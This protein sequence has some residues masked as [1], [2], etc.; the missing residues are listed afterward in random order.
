MK[1][2]EVHVGVDIAKDSLEVS[3]FDSKEPVVE[4]TFAGLES[5]VRRIKELGRP[6][7]V[8]CEATGGFEHGLVCACLDAGI[9]VA[10][11]NARRVRR[12]AQSQ[13]V[14]AKTDRIDARVIRDYAERSELRLRE[15]RA[16]WQVQAK[17]LL[18][19]R[20]ELSSMLVQEKNRL[21]ISP[22]DRVRRSIGEIVAAI[23]AQ[24]KQIDA[25]LKI[26]VKKNAEFAKSVARICG[27]KGVGVLSAMALLAFVPELG[28]VS[29]NEAAALVGVAPYNDDSG[30]V[31]GKRR[32]TGGR[33][34]VRKTL[35]MAALSASVHNPLLSAFHQRLVQK[36]KPHKVALTAVIR[37]IV[38]LANRLLADPEFELA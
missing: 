7:M 27:I 2:Y 17:A 5:L 25:E 24:I 10:V 9:P 3:P 23:R 1:A 32:T 18:T 6:A 11:V 14:L 19:R 22:D 28:E 29:G 35:Y 15:R 34:E 12:Y 21:G 16:A 13:G 30:T 36:G 37:K 31:K 8:C 26:L 4:N 20:N 33:S 38:V